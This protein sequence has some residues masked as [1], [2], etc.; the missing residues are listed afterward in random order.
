[1]PTPT[2]TNLTVNKTNLINPNMTHVIL[3][4]L[5]KIIYKIL[6][7]KISMIVISNKKLDKA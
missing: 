4:G 2:T 7:L 3:N 5:Q 1:M 6:Y